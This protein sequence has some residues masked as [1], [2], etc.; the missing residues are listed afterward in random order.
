ML[1]NGPI[2]PLTDSPVDFLTHSPVAPVFDFG[3]AGP[4]LH[5]ANANGYPPA[6]YTPLFEGLTPHYHVIAMRSRPLLPGADPA[7]LR[8]WLP[9]VDDLV[10]FLDGPGAAG[11]RDA[12]GWVGVGHSLGAVTTVLAALRRPELFRAIVAID[13]VFFNPL[14]L[15]AFDIVRGLGLAERVHPLIAGARRRRRVFASADEMFAR[16]RQAAVFSR[17]DDR[18]LRAYVDAVAAPRADGAGVELAFSPEWEA[19]IYATGP[20]NLWRQLVKL[21]VPMLVIR[22]ADSD[23]FDQGAVKALH[24]RLPAEVA[25]LILNF[26]RPG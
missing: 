2:D 15:A 18:S 23:T 11:A 13:P 1:P 16:Y 24:R 19:Q 9:L 25:Q 12:G 4:L 22:G 20:F 21:S 3:G 14:K 10:T 8:S 17:M 6:S 5:F 26:V 7:A